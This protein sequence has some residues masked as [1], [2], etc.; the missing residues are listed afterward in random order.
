MAGK[1]HA[2]SGGGTNA[3]SDGLGFVTT[4]LGS[5]TRHKSP[6]TDS[7]GSSELLYQ[8]LELLKIR[9]LLMYENLDDADMGEWERLGDRMISSILRLIYDDDEFVRNSAVVFARRLLSLEAFQMTI[10]MQLGKGAISVLN[11]FW[12]ATL[13]LPSTLLTFPE[14]LRR[15]NSWWGWNK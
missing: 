3:I 4:T 8:L 12:K 6:S 1:R 15:S 5:Q 10:D 11:F 9:P 7:I 14:R 13:V 2:N